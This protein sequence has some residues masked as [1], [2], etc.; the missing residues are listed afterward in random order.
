MKVK[1][2]QAIQIITDL[3]RAKLVPFI[4]GSPGI[5]KSQIVA[6]IAKMYGLKM[7]DLRL[8]TC[9]PTDLTGFPRITAEKAGYVPMDTFPIEGDP[10]PE[11]YNG[12]LLFLDEANSCSTAVQAAA[13]KLILDRMVGLHKLHKNVAIVCAGNKEDDGA[14]VETLSTAMQ[15]RL[16]HMELVADVQEWLNWAASNKLDHRI[17]SY[18]NF[19]PGN[20]YNFSPDHTDKTYA[21]PRT[22]E[23]AHR[24]LQV[25]NIDEPHL[26]AMLAGT[27]SEGVA[28]EFIAFC[29]NDKDLPKVADILKNPNALPVPKEPSVL[30]AITGSLAHHANDDNLSSL[31]TYMDRLPK[32]FQVI[33]LR[34]TMRRNDD[35]RRHKATLNWIVKNGSEFFD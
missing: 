3:I 13:Y 28:R 20:F 21:C 4:E 19:K 31:M 1:V 29:K 6:Q 35:L 34:E 18:I 32:E 15:S 23:F 33:W 25:T 27:L 24:V 12:W 17:T 16:V 10:V 7:I 5:G 8:S 26:M 11:G 30:Y 22:W 2:S 9:D 14:I